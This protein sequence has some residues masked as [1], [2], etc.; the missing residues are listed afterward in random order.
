[1]ISTKLL[2]A[3]FLLTLLIAQCVALAVA[4]SFPVALKFAMDAGVAIA[5]GFLLARS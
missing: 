2:L 4:S 3:L 1:M 5:I